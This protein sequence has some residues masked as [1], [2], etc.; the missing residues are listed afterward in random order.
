[1]GNKNCNN[2]LCDLT[3]SN[4]YQSVDYNYRAYIKYLTWIIKLA[5]NRF[6]WEGLPDSCDARVL[7]RSLLVNGVACISQPKDLP[8][9][10]SLPCAIQGSL[11]IYGNPTEWQAIGMNG[12]RFSSSWDYG[13]LVFNSKARLG[14]WNA[15]TLNAR[16]LAHYDRT[17]DINLAVQKTPYAITAPDSQKR[18]LINT[19]KNINEGEI[20]ILGD[21]NFNDI[22]NISAI[23][24]GVPFIGAQL[25]AAKRV[26]W[27]EIMTFLGIPSLP[28]EKGERMI[29]EEA[30]GGE[31]AANI[32][33]LDALDARREACDYLNNTFGLNVSVYFNKD[34][35]SANY[36]YARDMER[37]GELQDNLSLMAS[38]EREA[39]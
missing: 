15:I 10:F 4:F 26:L 14:V 37:Q 33:L 19:F 23:N 3:S 28:Y 9:F 6:R 17:E 7:E 31:A 13:A 39:Q 22:V 12:D 34:Y 30:K 18:A 1:M 11:N 35:E 29:E 38:E 25:G 2:K 5:M 36:N 21:E 20:A 27:S 24:L 32:M 8:V 16:K